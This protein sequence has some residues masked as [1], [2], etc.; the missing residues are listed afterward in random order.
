LGRLALAFDG[1]HGVDGATVHVFHDEVDFALIE[2]TAVIS[3]LELY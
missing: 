1:D 3:D 2:E